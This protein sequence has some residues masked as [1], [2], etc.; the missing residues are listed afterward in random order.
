MSTVAEVAQVSQ[1]LKP[2]I[3]DLGLIL[4][5][6]G[7]AVLLF[8]KIKQPLVL[9]YLIAGFLAGN[10]FDFFPSVKDVHSVEIWAEIG[11]IILLFSLGLEFSFKKLMKVGGTASITAITQIITMVLVGYLVGKWMGWKNMDC[12]FLGVILSISSTTIILK[13]FDELGV[14]AQQFA[15]IV[16]GSLIVQ[17]IIAILMMVLLS[18]VAVSQQF[19]GSEL[20]LSVLKLVFFLIAWFVGGIFFIPTLLKKTK[21]LL[22]DEMML[23]LSLALCLMMV[24]LASNA[25]FSPALG[26]FIMG[27]IIAETT[28]AEHI[29]HLVK[30]V[31]DLFGAVFFVSVGMLINPHTLYE[32]A[33]PV[34]IL[35]FVTIFGQSI[36]STLG[37]IISGQPLKQSVQTGMSLAQIGE[38]SFII[39]TLGM[40]M[41]V[42][43]NFLYPVVVAVSAVT[44]FTTPFMVKM[45]V[46]FSGYL[47]K[48]LPRKWIRRIDRYSANAQAIRSVS[49]WQVVIR[50]HLLQILLHT[51]IITSVILLSS[52][53]VLPLVA[54]SKFGNAIAALITM[55]VISPFL[56]ALSLRRVAVKEVDQ[57]FEERKYRGPILMLFFFRMGLAVFYIGFLLNIF[58]SPLIA[59]F[60]LVMAIVIYLLFPKQLHEQYHKIENHFLT[61]LNDREE[62]RIDRRYANLHPWD[63]HMT[64]FEIS[65]ESNLVGKTLREIKMR[66]LVGVNITYIKRGEIIIQI[67]NKNERLFPGDEICV[68]GSD[69]QVKEFSNFLNQHDIEVPEKVTNE[70]MLRQVELTNEDFIGL[71]VGQS[72][73]RE[74]THGLLVGIERKG[75]RILNPESNIILEKNDLLWIVGDK[76]L[77]AQLFKA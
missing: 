13:T 21:H 55:V 61:N 44:T 75:Q 24:I 38:F 15:G 48:K 6:A 73:L 62:K 69:A 27:S 43:S 51:I 46:P 22:T 72:K 77:I 60:A 56:W 36:S 76:K 37:A 31:K 53:F 41:N 5:T 42:T 25:G 30:P 32:Y 29:E 54:D 9:G 45:A 19:S 67:P 74:R 28:Q 57:L 71:S 64:T 18:T 63:G 65:K 26:A 16:I 39:A 14:K 68:I 49:T 7:I 35:T 40:S 20:M 1:H 12:I 66:E 23:I 34:M 17:D 10:H 33:L 59:M 47:E 2:L 4:M 8:K 70:I 52:K 3:S 11:V 50:A 58:F